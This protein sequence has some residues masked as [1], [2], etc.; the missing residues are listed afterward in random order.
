MDPVER[1]D[2]YLDTIRSHTE[3]MFPIESRG[4]KLTISNVRFVDASRDRAANWPELHKIKTQEKSFVGRLVGDLTLQD[5]TTGA[6]LETKKNYTLNMFPH[7]TAL[8]SFIVDGKELQMVNQLRRLPG[9]YPIV[10]PD[11]NTVSKITSAGLNHDAIFDRQTGELLL[12]VKSSHLKLVPL[13]R[14]LGVPHD[15]LE[16]HLGKDIVA[17]NL[18]KEGKRSELLR[19][20]ELM[21]RVPAPDT[22]EAL[23]E[24]VTAFLGSK[25]VNPDVTEDT[26]GAKHQVLSPK[27]Y[28]DAARA[29]IEV[30][31]GQ[32]EPADM[33]SL[34]YKSIHSVED[35]VD[36][37]LKAA[38]PPLKRRIAYLMD[39]KSKLPEMLS[40][41]AMSKP[42]FQKF[43]QSE[44]SR[45][46]DQ[47]N[48]LDILAVNHT[49]TS[50]GEGGIQSHHAITDNLRNVHNSHFGF[51]DPVNTSEDCYAADMEVMTKNGW[52]PWPQV[53]STD[54]FACLTD[55]NRVEF[56]PASVM[57]CYDHDGPMLGLETQTLSFLVT[58]HHRL[59]TRPGGVAKPKKPWHKFTRAIEYRFERA[60][61]GFGK[62]RR[63]RCGGHLPYVGNHQDTDFFF[64]P[65]VT[66]GNAVRNRALLDLQDFAELLGW[67]LSEGSFEY[68]KGKKR[69]KLHISQSITANPQNVERIR[70]LLERMRL[71]AS[72]SAPAKMFTI[73]SKQL[74]DYFQ[75]FGKSWDKFIPEDAFDWPE[76]ARRRLL[77]SL[78]LGDGRKPQVQ[79]NWTT[80][81]Y[82]TTSYRL[83]HDVQRLCF[84]LGI[85][86][87][88]TERKDSREEHYHLQY[89][90]RLHSRQEREIVPR[91]C[92]TR[93]YF[94]EH[95]VGK[96][97]CATVP[98]GRLYVRRH[99]KSGH[100]NGNSSIGVVGKA[101]V[102][103]RKNGQRLE[104][105]VYDRTE[106]RMK[107]VTPVDIARD[108]MAFPEQFDVKDGHYTPKKKTVFAVKK[109]M[110]KAFPAADVRYVLPS[111]Q[112]AFSLVTNAIPFMHTNSANRMLMA[113]RHLEQAVPL[114]E[115]EAPLVQ[116]KF[117]GVSYYDV[118][119]AAIAAMAERPGRVRSVKSDH[120]QL[121]YDGDKTPTKLYFPNNYRLNSGSLLHSEPLVKA[122]ARVKAG[123]LLLSSS[124]ND[125]KTYAP[126]RH[127]TTAIMP[128]RGLS[129]E[130]GL[131]VSEDAARKLASEHIH[132]V[133]IDHE[134]GVELS[135]EKVFA[136]Y[137]SEREKHK[138][139]GVL[140]KVGQ[141]LKPGD[142][143]LPAVRRQELNVETDYG[144]I[145]KAL[146]R[147]FR[148]ISAYWDHHLDG[149]VDQVIKTPR[150]TKVYV[151]TIEP[152]QVGDK[153]S[154]RA[155]SKG[156]VTKILPMAETPRLKDGTPVDVLFNPIGIPGRVNATFL[157]ENA[158]SKIARKTGKPYI[159]ESFDTTHSAAE[160]VLADLK[161]HGISD[162]EDLVDPT[163]N[164]TH[165]NIMVGENYWLKLKHQVRKKLA[166]RSHEGSYTVE[167]SPARGG[168]ESAQGFG[169]LDLYALLSNGYTH[170]LKDAAGVKSTRQV[171]YWSNLQLGL[172][173]PPP[174]TPFILDK[175]M[176][177]LEGAGL[178][179]HRQGDN[180]KITPFTDAEVLQRSKGVVRDPNVFRIGKNGLEPE[181][182]GLFDPVI[183]GGHGSDHWS[184]I[185][186][187]ERQLNPLYEIPVKM[188]TGIKT[189]D[190]DA[191]LAGTKF[192]DGKT[193][194]EAVTHLL[195]QVDVQR[196]LA[197]ARA[198]LRTAKVAERDNLL[199]R[200][201]YLSALDR[202]KLTP[203]EAYTNKYIPVVPTK[204]RP[205]YDLPDGSLN[206]ADANHG[207]REV[208]FINRELEQLKRQN[209]DDQHLAPLRAQLYAAY[210][211][212]T[213]LTE[214]VT[215]S[216]HFRGFISQIAGA[217]NKEGMFQA[218]VVSRRQ[219]LSGRSTAT[220]EPT[221][222]MDEVGLPEDMTK[223]IFK[224][225]IIR[226]L[227]TLYGLTPLDARKEV[228]TLTDRARLAM[229]DEMAERPVLM[230]R[231]PA[232]HKF[233]EVAQIARPVSGKSIRANPLIFSGLNLDLDGD[234]QIGSVFAAISSDLIQ[235]G[236]SLQWVDSRAITDEMS[237]RIREVVGYID[238]TDRLVV[239]DLADFPHGPLV[240]RQA[241]REFYSVPKGIRVITLD[242]GGKPVLA[243]VSLW[244]VHRERAVEIVRL[245]GGREIITDDDPRGIYGLDIDTLTWVRRR[246]TEARRVLVPVARSLELLARPLQPALRW[247][248]EDALSPKAHRLKSNVPQTREAGYF[249][250]A[251][252]GDGWTSKAGCA[253]GQSQLHLASLY[254]EVT[255]AWVDGALQFFDE[256][257]PKQVVGNVWTYDGKLED[258]Q[259]TARQTILSTALAPRVQLQ[260][261]HGAANKHLPIRWFQMSANFLWGLLAGLWDTDGTCCWSKASPK[262]K[263]QFQF[264]YSSNSLRLVREL[265][266][267]LRLL[268]IESSIYAT[269]TPKGVPAW[270]VSAH[271]LSLHRVLSGGDL[272]IQHTEKVKFLA[273][274][275]AADAP[276]DAPATMTRDVVPFPQTLGQELARLVNANNSLMVIAYRSAKR[277]TIPRATA[278]R[279]IEMVSVCANPLYPRWVEIVRDDRVRFEEII[280]VDRTGVVETGYDLTVPGYETFMNVDGVILSN[281]VGVHV[282][283]S[284]AAREELLQK[285]PSRNMISP[286]SGDVIHTVGK[287]ALLGLFE[288]TTPDPTLPVIPGSSITKVL[289]DHATRPYALNQ[290]VKI[291]GKTWTVGH[292]L[293]NHHLP[294]AM[295]LKDPM[296]VTGSVAR[297]WFTEVGQKHPQDAGRVINALKDIGFDAATRIAT[298]LNLRDMV[299][300]NKSRDVIAK[301]VEAMMQKDPE[302]A[303]LHAAKRL[304]ELLDEEVT[305]QNTFA[306]ITY[307]SGASGKHKLN[308]RQLI[309]AP[310]G[311]TDVKGKVVPIPIMRSYADGLTLPQYWATMPGARKGIA[312]RAV[313]TQ[314]TGAFTKELVNTAITV[315]VTSKDCFT[316]QGIS[317]S[318]DHPDIAGRYI[319]DGPHR[320]ELIDAHLLTQLRKEGKPVLVRSAL[321]CQVPG[322]GLCVKCAGLN[323]AGREHPV[324][325][326]IGPY[327]ATTITE[328]LTQGVMRC[329]A[330]ENL[331]TAKIYGQIQV[332]SLKQLWEALPGMVDVVGRVEHKVVQNV[333]VFDGITWTDVEHIERHEPDDQLVV[334]LLTNGSSLVAQENH[335]TWVRASDVAC[336]CGS[337]FVRESGREK[338]TTAKSDDQKVYVTCSVCGIRFSVPVSQWPRWMETV[339]N[340]GDS[341]G[342]FV[343]THTLIPPTAIEPELGGYTAGF[344][345]AEGSVELRQGPVLKSGARRSGNLPAGM[346]SSAPIAVTFCQN[347]GAAQDYAVQRIFA[348]TGCM[349]N[350]SGKLMRF[351]DSMLARK[352][353]AWFGT[354]AA[355]KQLPAAWLGASETWLINFLAGVLDGDGHR[356]ERGGPSLDTTSLTLAYQV[357]WI[358]KRLGGYARVYPT[359]WRK[360]SKNQSY[361]VDLY[362]PR[363]I[364]GFKKFAP[365]LG[366]VRG[367][368]NALYAQVR[369]LKRIRY[370]G[371]VYDLATTTRRFALNGVVTHNSFHSQGAVGGQEVGY[372][373]VRQ[374]VTM[375]ENIRGKAVLAERDGIVGAI[376]QTDRGGAEVT[377]D[378]LTHFVPTEVGLRVKVGERVARGDQ[379]SQHGALKIQE[380]AELRGHAAARDQL[381][382]DLDAAMKDSGQN[383]R[384]RIYEIAVKPLVDKVEVVAANDGAKDGV[385][386]GD[387]MNASMVRE[388]NQTRRYKYPIEVKPI[389]MSI[390]EVPFEADNFIGSLMFQRLPRTL[391]EAPA[392][393]A[394]APLTETHPVVDYAFKPW[395]EK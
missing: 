78:L 369:A 149:V 145:H 341:T 347:P 19:F 163:H 39:R 263:P 34:V 23:R 176:T 351:Y 120:I 211:G 29:A 354:H 205:I 192:V 32:R 135:E 378:G 384:R 16:K 9:V 64:L 249:F 304:D 25:V 241:T 5:K 225:F 302:K 357:Q 382:N 22:H 48:P 79:K 107:W 388:L 332:L 155:G 179:V 294:E 130:D 383:I 164:K 301:E 313:S 113:D 100:W 308:V 322:G 253:S 319:A 336:A 274:F 305:D 178:R 242:A 108:G 355:N 62:S 367:Y 237:A 144:R 279:I 85:S 112:D 197:S 54:L 370:S 99:N 71:Q 213:G 162:T 339:V 323:E 95:Y 386:D 349:P 345:A 272:R 257:G 156:I 392:V 288:A 212:L 116:P 327:A 244:S 326:A 239:C 43:V 306:R 235:S 372:K 203:V 12:K 91:K 236:L 115:R 364:D 363:E 50:L 114:I 331:V 198:K 143:V 184:H 376:T 89:V 4:K 320:G 317:M 297:K 217:Q 152:L 330:G 1:F 391:R 73:S 158:A 132:E 102:G 188:L 38:Y 277:G 161:K 393:G 268:G 129:Y 293:I 173:T 168:G 194:G 208:L 256:T 373:R 81:T 11:N 83:A 75:K 243:P 344:F 394:T 254:P 186:L 282:P 67:V 307:K 232:L 157:L 380:V 122:G 368:H 58:P 119:G 109:S 352:F 234:Q 285:L 360:H 359:P 259:G 136:Y 335:P 353:Q 118:M 154:G 90:V 226:R 292:L 231:A 200:I 82:A 210:A 278:R 219:D 224:P 196:D 195:S 187:H 160:K 281:T 185:E 361:R 146:R 300:H 88:V 42:I 96:V 74:T 31:R 117:Q 298:S 139:E 312:D 338:R 309:L 69:Y 21:R 51:L 45:Y 390:R 41:T 190:L 52:K 174:K 389:V 223:E 142:L 111:S 147:P 233:S 193:G 33:E 283:V 238:P 104:R 328:P 124:V 121:V 126:G 191:I 385:T 72:F 167:E 321:T 358:A 329:S 343:Q 60:D 337:P 371:K 280:S 334:Q 10:R 346:H 221:L 269:R 250:G 291:D 150:V 267:L 218:R 98:Y 181:R 206:V 248:R 172:P 216:G 140:P 366:A 131:V 101:A 251:M 63:F 273:E 65:N 151:R 44:F 316:R 207:Y 53:R 287:E 59:W 70:Q 171:D 324:G 290:P 159:V 86:S 18:A 350:V 356:S 245:S 76:A 15:D 20:H 175:F 183:T 202:L 182:E 260:I 56:H 325:F 262:K 13:L 379:L 177:T 377:I 133:R 169:P 395:T 180:I 105:Q 261:G 24:S 87:T 138:H 230:N 220:I 310:G 80:W 289:H 36:E 295:R 26:L 84:G 247:A 7:V 170:F 228:E 77:E 252:V 276:A 229:H 199:K 264:T 61:I 49:V 153:L 284:E 3:Q 375:P 55:D 215:R 165:K 137:P 35:F 123:Q 303:V 28:L 214:P 103:V 318:P 266:L 209:V 227:T 270:V 40:V 240:S 92:L 296:P 148:N 14:D 374:I 340:L 94:T 265:K 222:S 201:R 246:P 93:G 134:P 46:S 258:S 66:G 362:I 315:R 275:L 37:S 381:I 97:Y 6:T 128:W 17:R 255:A 286:K 189:T 127:L 106:K 299:A 57:H 204:F 125:Q 166:A 110:L 68:N 311:V 387:I 348:E 271:L 342:L 27:L 47:S 333:Q 30:A 141:V 314:D 2:R 8:G 365:K